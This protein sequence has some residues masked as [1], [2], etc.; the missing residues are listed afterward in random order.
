MKLPLHIF[1]SSPG[2]SEFNFYVPE[3]SSSRFKYSIRTI[4]REIIVQNLPFLII[5]LYF[6]YLFLDPPDCFYIS[7]LAI[8]EPQQEKEI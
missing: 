5:S 2:S 1:N 8:L 6:R 7:S 4:T 3:K